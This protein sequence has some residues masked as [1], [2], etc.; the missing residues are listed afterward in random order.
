LIIYKISAQR[1]P[2]FGWDSFMDKN[3]KKGYL[4]LLEELNWISPNMKFVK[5]VKKNAIVAE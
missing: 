3:L 2:A 4:K 1:V 5:N